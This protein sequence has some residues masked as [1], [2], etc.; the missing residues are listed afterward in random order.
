[1]IGALAYFGVLDPSNFAAERCV[2]T[3]PLS[4]DGQ[5]YI[6]EAGSAQVSLRN[7][8]NENLNLTDMRYRTASADWEDCDSYT[9]A[10]IP[11]GRTG[12]FGCNFTTDLTPGS[13]ERVEFEFKACY[14]GDEGCGFARTNTV[15]I[16]ANVQE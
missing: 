11:A 16:Y 13:R 15:E 9:T 8:F 2:A 6:L 14:E 1:M 5:N 7:G 10:N 3:T 4:C 12:S